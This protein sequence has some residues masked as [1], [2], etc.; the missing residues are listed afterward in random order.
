MNEFKDCDYRYLNN[1]EL[2]CKNKKG[3]N[4]SCDNCMKNIHLNCEY[5]VPKNDM[6]LKYFELGISSVSQYD[7]CAEKVLYDDKELS[8]KWSN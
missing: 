4:I 1:D 5:Y 8:R 6:C 7:D 2:A 3:L